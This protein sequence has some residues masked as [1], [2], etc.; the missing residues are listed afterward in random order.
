MQPIPG[1][2]VIYFF[3]IALF[4]GCRFFPESQFELAPDS[5][6]PKWFTVPENLSR[7]D[8]TVRMSYYIEPCVRSAK[9]SGLGCATF[10][11]WDIH[12]YMHGKKQ[13]VIPQPNDIRYFGL[14]DMNG[15][16]PTM[17]WDIWFPK[18]LAEVDAN[19]MEQ[20]NVEGYPSFVTLNARG[21]A[22]VIEHKYPGDVF[23]I[24][25]GVAVKEELR[26]FIPNGS[27]TQK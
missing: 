8:V 9:D 5:R 12:A 19:I 27:A 1:F 23:Y 6:L 16:K 24:D 4:S 14:L 7:A 17:S 11:L 2:R 18:K 21:I 3:M 26:R 25:D 10:E 22:E 15:Q 20:R 13:A